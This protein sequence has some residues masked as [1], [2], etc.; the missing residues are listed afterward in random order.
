MATSGKCCLCGYNGLTI[1]SCH[2]S[3]SGVHCMHWQSKGEANTT[4]LANNTCYRREADYASSEL[5]SA[6]A[7]E[8]LNLAYLVEEAVAQ[9]IDSGAK[10]GA[11]TIQILGLGAFRV[12]V[13]SLDVQLQRK[14]G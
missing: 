12:T 9:M 1:L 3:P 13:E 7:I 14:G 6:A 11:C 2:A 8:R 5:H 4:C 10:R